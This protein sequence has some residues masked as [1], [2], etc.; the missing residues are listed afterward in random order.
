MVSVSA[1]FIL[2]PNVVL[3][4]STLISLCRVFFR[5]IRHQVIYYQFPHHLS[6][7]VLLSFDSSCTADVPRYPTQTLSVQLSYAN[8]RIDALLVTICL[9]THNVFPIC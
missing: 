4:F 1:S 5:C 7:S 6:R 2:H 3:I 8:A 9:H